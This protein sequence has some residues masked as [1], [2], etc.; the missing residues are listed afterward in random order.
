MYVL[1]IFCFS[2]NP[3]EVGFLCCDILLCVIGG[4]GV[5]RWLEWDIGCLCEVLLV[6]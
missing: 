2:F 3:D 5:Q 4:T 1:N 6:S